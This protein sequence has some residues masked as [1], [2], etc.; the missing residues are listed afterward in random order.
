MGNLRKLRRDNN[1]CLYCGGEL[2]KEGIYCNK[3]TSKINKMKHNWV[4]ERHSKG[5]CVNCNKKIDREKGWFCS[6]CTKK[7]N[8]RAKIR[9]AYRRANGLC[10]QCGETSGDYSYCQRCRDMRMKRY[11]EKKNK[12]HG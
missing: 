9:N 2:D 12:N 1:L 5:Y 4:L 8:T 7:L 3:C 11:W 10:V 6:E